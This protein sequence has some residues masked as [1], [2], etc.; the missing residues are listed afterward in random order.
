M[1]RKKNDNDSSDKSPSINFKCSAELK[2]D[3]EDLAH[4]RKQKVSVMMIE[5][6]EIVIGNFREDIDNFRKLTSK[7]IKFTLKPPKATKKKTVSQQVTNTGDANPAPM[8]DDNPD[9]GANQHED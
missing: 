4:L 1:V 5:L 2:A 8:N 7:P 6:C 9:K 3:I